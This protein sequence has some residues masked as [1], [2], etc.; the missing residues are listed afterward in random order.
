MTPP[1][2]LGNWKMHCTTDEARTLTRRIARG[3][4]AFTDVEIA[5]A[6]PFTALATVAQ[7]LN[8]SRVRLAAQDVHWEK[9]GAFTGEISPGMLLDSGCKFVIVGH[10]E[11]RRLFGESDRIIAQKFAASMRAGL[12]PVLCIGETLDERRKGRTT[13]VIGRQLRGALKGLAKDAIRK[14]DVAYEPVWAIGTGHN[15]TPEQVSSVHRWIRSFLMGKFKRTSLSRILYGGSVNP[16]NAAELAQLHNVD[17]VLVGGAS[18]RA[19]GF[20]EIVRHFGSA[21][22]K[23]RLFL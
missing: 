13:Q 3:A 17:G 6:P 5:I 7:V 10:S 1:L 9:A 20:L 15:A 16:E 23:S 22:K 14:F 11:R 4:K 21:S 8:R 19:S 2:V 18:L 12:R